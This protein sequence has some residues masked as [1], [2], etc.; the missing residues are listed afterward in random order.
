MVKVIVNGISYDVPEEIA[1]EVTTA[2]EYRFYCGGR[3]PIEV[4]KY[5]VEIQDR[6][7]QI[8]EEVKRLN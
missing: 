3:S 4:K 6:I 7:N 1:V 5:L 8:Y 2:R